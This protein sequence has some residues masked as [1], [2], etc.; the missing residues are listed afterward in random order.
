MLK[1]PNIIEYYDSFLHDRA[2]MIVMEYAAGG[3]LYDLLESRASEATYLDEKEEIAFL[4]A[5]IVLSMQLIHSR[6][7]LHRDLKSQNIFLSRN[8]DFVKVSKQEAQPATYI[9]YICYVADRGFWH[10]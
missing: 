1:H 10:Q 4:F 9:Y 7:I 6:N 5:Q 2:M 3:T 8:R